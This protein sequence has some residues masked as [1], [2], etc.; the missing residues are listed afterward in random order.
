MAVVYL[1]QACAH[2]AVHEHKKKNTETNIAPRPNKINK[3]K[4]YISVLAYQCKC[5]LQYINRINH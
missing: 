1:N 4:E 5:H 2:F 3:E